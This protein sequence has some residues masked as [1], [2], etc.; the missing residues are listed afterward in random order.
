[1]GRAGRDPASPKAE[2]RH[3]QAVVLVHVVHNYPTNFRLSDLTR[4]LTAESGAFAER[5]GIERAVRDLVAVGL[6]FRC[7][8]L[9]LPTRAALCLYEVLI[10]DVA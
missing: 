1:M 5:D 3:D 9:V 10:K 2:D 4:E 6:L 7:A 8:G